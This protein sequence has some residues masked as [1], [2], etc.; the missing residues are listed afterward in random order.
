MHRII[1]V[2]RPVDRGK[3]RSTGPVDRLK[4]DCSRLGPVDRCARFLLPFG[5]QIPFL[6]GIEFNLGFLKFSDSVAI[7][8][9]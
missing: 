8:K 1:T 7:N 5:I 6:D 2:A 3:E 9:G 4:A